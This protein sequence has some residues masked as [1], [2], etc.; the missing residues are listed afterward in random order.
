M[1]LEPSS[2]DLERV[3]DGCGKHAGRDASKHLSH[4]HILEF[5]VEHVVKAT[6][7]SLLETAGQ[8]SAE[9][10]LEAFLLVYIDSGRPY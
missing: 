3:S 7:S 8:P 5:L 1:S 9:E 2:D 4:A 6:K 10:G